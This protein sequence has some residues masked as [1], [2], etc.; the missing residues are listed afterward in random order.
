MQKVKNAYYIAK[1]FN[2][3]FERSI[4]SVIH[5]NVDLNSNDNPDPKV[6]FVDNW[7]N[8]HMKLGE[9]HCGS[10]VLK[11]LPKIKWYH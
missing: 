1:Q 11:E 2:E 3:N 5:P 9:V 4:Y 10:N 6:Y 7:D 8:Y